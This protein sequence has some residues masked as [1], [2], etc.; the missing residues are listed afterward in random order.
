MDIS[1]SSTHHIC[2]MKEYFDTFQEGSGK[3]FSL[4]NESKCDVMGVGIVKIEMFDGVVPTLGGDVC[5][6]V[7]KEFIIFEPVRLKRLQMYFCRGVMNITRG[8]MVLIKGEEC[9]GLYR[10]IGCAK[11]SISMVVWKLRAQENRYLRRLSFVGIEETR[12]KCFQGSNDGEK[13]NHDEEGVRLGS[14]FRA[15]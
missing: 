6:K 8:C 4:P 15:D 9:G 12:V 3:S 5:P 10:Q 2:S 13:K 11:A 14:F 7:G 1:S